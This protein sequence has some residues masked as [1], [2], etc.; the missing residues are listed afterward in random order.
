MHPGHGYNLNDFVVFAASNS[1]QTKEV[2]R[3][4]DK[5]KKKKHDTVFGLTANKNT[6]WKSLPTP[7]MC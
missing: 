5:L 4:V 1:G 3:L 6:S 7:P 2:I